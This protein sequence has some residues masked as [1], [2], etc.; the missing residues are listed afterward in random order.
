MRVMLRV[1]GML[2]ERILMRNSSDS[3]KMSQ[4]PR[5]PRGEVE[6]RRGNLP[7]TSQSRRDL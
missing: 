4:R 7:E 5:R 3:L 2:A 1:T 6:R